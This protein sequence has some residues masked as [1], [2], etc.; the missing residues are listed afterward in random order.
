M[1]IASA[2]VLMAAQPAVNEPTLLKP[3]VVEAKP[4]VLQNVPAA[5]TKTNTP[6]KQSGMIIVT[7]EAAVKLPMPVQAAMVKARAQGQMQGMKC[8]NKKCGGKKMMKANKMKKQMNSP[9]LIKHGLPH[10]TKMVMP[11]LNDPA[12]NLTTEQKAKL[13]KVRMTTMKAIMEA[14]PEIMALRKEIVD[15]SVSGTSSEALKDKVAKLA[16]LEAAATMTHLKCIEATKEILTKDQLFFL[17]ANK[18][19]KMNHG[20]K[21]MMMRGNVQPKMMMMKINKPQGQGMKCAPGKCGGN[22]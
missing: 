10:L 19:K 14:K 6:T 8:G 13:A 22:K 21:P 18:N 17:L 20:R 5:A 16:L 12:F 1:M 11:Y 3:V 7:K 2:S 15:A 9:F 4:D